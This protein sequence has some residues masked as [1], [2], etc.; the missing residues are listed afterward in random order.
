LCETYKNCKAAGKPFEVIFVSGDKD[1]AGFKSYLSEMAEKGGDWL[2]IPFGDSRKNW[3]NKYFETEG[4]PHM[5][6][7]DA[8]GTMINKNARGSVSDDKSG[9]KFPWVPPLVSSLSQ[10]EGIDESTS[11]AVL[12]ESS[13]AEEQEKAMKELEVV[14]KKYIDEAKAAG[15]DPKYLFFLAKNSQGPVPRI[16]ELCGLPEAGALSNTQVKTS[17]ETSPVGLVRSLSDE[18]AKKAGE[19]QFPS[20]ILLD[21]PDS[22][23]FYISDA[24]DINAANV[25]KLIADF[26][27]KTLTRKQLGEG[28]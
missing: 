6:V 12:M 9:E 18:V 4:I 23:G 8:Q 1:E 19:A 22:G 21:I 5:A 16:R 28:Q 13:S 11:I 15:E 20:L 3:L 24:T 26:E 10:P 27:G 25:Q 14:A 17:E 2:A 7:V